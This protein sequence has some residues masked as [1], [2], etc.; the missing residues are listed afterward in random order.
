MYNITIVFTKKKFRPCTNELHKITDNSDMAQ[1]M[2][3]KLFSTPLA[4]L[5][6]PDSSFRL[7]PGPL[8][9]TEKSEKNVR[10]HLM[11]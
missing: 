2:E 9:L 5:A 6:S 7:G 3:E 8:Q 1:V 10:N 11:K 4:G